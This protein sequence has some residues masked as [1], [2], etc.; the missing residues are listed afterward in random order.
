MMVS[1]DHPKVNISQRCKLL[2]VSRSSL[3][4]KP[5][6]ESMLNLKLMEEMD[7]HF[8]KHPYK[9]VPRMHVYLTKDIEYKINYKRTER[10]F[11]K[12]MGLQTVIPGPHTSKPN[13]KHKIYPYLLRGYKI[14]RF[15]EVWAT[16]ITYIAMEK[17]FMYLIAIIDLHSRYVLKWSVSN[18]LDAQ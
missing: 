10:L 17:G 12:V 9:G 3:Y 5:K 6:G 4:R 15:N 8:L 1:K 16:D 18:T 2:S 14:K 11:S 13:S 7:K